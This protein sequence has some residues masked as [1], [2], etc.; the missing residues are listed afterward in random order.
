[1]LIVN[2]VIIVVIAFGVGFY[3]GKGK[4]EITK[5]ANKADSAKMIEIQEDML[6]IQK[7]MEQEQVK[8]LKEYNAEFNNI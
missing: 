6:R 7:E 5:K 3:L 1:M 2:I 4:I 8:H